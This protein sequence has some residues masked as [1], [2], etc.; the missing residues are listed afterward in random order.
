MQ[1][2]SALD[3]RTRGVA[4][5]VAAAWLPFHATGCGVSSI[6]YLITQSYEG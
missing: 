2:T 4:T 5:P 6:S 3:E 1:I